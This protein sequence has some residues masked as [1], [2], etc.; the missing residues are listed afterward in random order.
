MI[1]ERATS[2][3]VSRL[4]PEQVDAV[5]SARGNQQPPPR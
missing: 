1:Y 2:V 5:R 4:T 3:A